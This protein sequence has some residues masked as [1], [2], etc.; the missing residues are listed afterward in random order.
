M[1]CVCMRSA[2]AGCHVFFVETSSS[3]I[4]TN[5]NHKFG[6]RYLLTFQIKML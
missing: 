4:A 2:R 3:L 5:K 1:N 6:S